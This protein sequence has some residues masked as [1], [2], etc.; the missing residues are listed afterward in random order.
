MKRYAIPTTVGLL[1]LLAFGNFLFSP[2][3]RPIQARAGIG[4]T[5][6]APS[7]DPSVFMRTAPLDLK[8]ETWSPI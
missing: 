8:T 6:N 7:I 4:L 5:S 1:I 2:F 3:S